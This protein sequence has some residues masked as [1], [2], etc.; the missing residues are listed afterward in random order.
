M[1]N[2]IFG[3]TKEIQIL[4]AILYSKSSEFIAIYGRRR[5]GKTYLIREYFSQKTKDCIYCEVIGIKDGALQDQLENFAEG[6][7]KTFYKN[8]PIKPLNNWREALN[9]LT[10]AIESI[11]KSQKIVIFF[12][13]LPWMATPKS[14][15][16][17]NLDYCWNSKWSRISNL[18]I[19]V[20]GSA[21]AWILENLIN[22]KGGLHNRLTKTIL[23]E[24]FNLFETKMFLK[25]QGIELNNKQILDIYMV[26]GGVPFYLKQIQKGRSAAQNINEICFH[27]EGFLYNEFNRI[28]K[29]LFDEAEVNLIIIKEIAVHRHGIVRQKL[30]KKLNMSSGGTFNKRITELETA[31][32]IQSFTPYGR[33]IKDHYY[34]V[35]DEYTLFYLTWIEPSARSKFKS[36]QGI[37]WPS[38]VNTGIWCNWVGYAFEQICYKHTEQIRKALGIDKIACSIGSWQYI[39]KKGNKDPGAQIDLLFDRDDGAISICEIK[40]SDHEFTIDKYYAKNLL[41]KLETFEKYSSISAKKQLF[42]A[43]VTVD[44]I[45]KNIWY[46]DLIH[47]QVLLKDIMA[48]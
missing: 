40:Y 1:E 14:N 15:L 16:L 32:F 24:P 45:K 43:I 36:S 5:V 22:A 13:E 46:E 4:D 2:Y 48:F 3:R 23:L 34:K 6:L 21:A 30:L 31:G 17:Q 41:N 35:I 19:I 10:N 37:Y 44:G 33:K 47:N 8:V 9:L 18:K 20:C 12:D 7:S 26:M 39:Q 29:S 27:Q 28:F 25:H 42:L 11:P 38:K